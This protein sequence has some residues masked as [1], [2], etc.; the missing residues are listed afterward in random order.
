MDLHGLGILQAAV[1]IKAQTLKRLQFVLGIKLAVGAFVQLHGRDTSV[2][3]EIKTEGRSEQTNLTEVTKHKTACFRD[4]VLPLARSS[5][6]TSNAAG[7]KTALTCTVH[8][9]L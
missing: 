8:G 4:V 9:H 5:L 7:T 6:I 1:S 2:P 3:R